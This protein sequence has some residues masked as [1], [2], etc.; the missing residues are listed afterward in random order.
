LLIFSLEK[1]ISD[2]GEPVEFGY[3]DAPAFAAGSFATSSDSTKNQRRLRS[4][5]NLA[6]KIAARLHQDISGQG[7][8]EYAL[9]MALVVFAAVT[10]MRGLANEIN[11]AFSQITSTLT[12]SIT[13]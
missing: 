3:E 8:V 5:V 12:S 6:R 10:T 11:L 1:S 9:I 4:M 13:P 7:L 2:F